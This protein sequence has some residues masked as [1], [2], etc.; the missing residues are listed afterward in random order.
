[1]RV[2]ANGQRSGIAQVNFRDLSDD[3]VSS[4]LGA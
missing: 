4:G 2:P 1:M 3:R